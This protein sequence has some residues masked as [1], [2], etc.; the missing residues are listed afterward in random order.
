VHP[1]LFP[2]TV[3]WLTAQ[4]QKY[5]IDFTERN[6]FTGLASG[7]FAAGH[8]SPVGMTAEHHHSKC[9]IAGCKNPVS[10]NGI[11]YYFYR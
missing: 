4:V 3:G 2:S 11:E 9:D 7:D 10:P 1:D 8:S 5:L 6:S